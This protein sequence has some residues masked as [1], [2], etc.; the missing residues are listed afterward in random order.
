MKPGGS[1]ASSIGP[2]CLLRFLE[3]GPAFSPS[4]SF[5]TRVS[6]INITLLFSLS[7]YDA[8][9][10]AYLSA[11]EMAIGRETFIGGYIASDASFFLSRIDRLI[12]QLLMQRD[13]PGDGRSLLT[14]LRGKAAVASAKL[15]YRS[16]RQ[17][18]TGE[19]WER[20]AVKGAKVERPL[21]ASTGIKDASYSDVDHVEPRIGRGQNTM[22]KRSARSQTTE[23]LNRIKLSKVWNRRLARSRTFLMPALTCTAWPGNWS[24]K[25]SSNLTKHSTVRTRRW[26]RSDARPSSNRQQPESEI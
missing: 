4:S 18:F 20:L 10:E 14:T 5:C 1:V 13:R 15:A 6:C 19:R 9:I 3:R 17:A 11:L 22:R 16:F 26:K 21:W 7:A 23:K 24:T 2:M 8:V 12:D 25:A